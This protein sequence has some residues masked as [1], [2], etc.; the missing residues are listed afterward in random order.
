MMFRNN[1]EAN[2]QVP[3][4]PTSQTCPRHLLTVRDV[5]CTE[6]TPVM[7]TPDMHMPTVCTSWHQPYQ[8]PNSLR[9]SR[10]A[11]RHPAYDITSRR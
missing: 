11:L 7:E 3:A 9:T 10:S 4:P 5:H 2:R 1:G 6:L 8:H